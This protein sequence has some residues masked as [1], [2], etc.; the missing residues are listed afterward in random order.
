MPMLLGNVFQQL[1]NMIDSFVV[2]QFVGKQAL[3][4]VGQSFPVMFVSL[5]LIM[6]ITLAG[7]ILIAQF[8]G[9]REKGMM[10]DIVDATLWITKYVA[11]AMTVL[12][13]AAAPALL[14]L[15]QTPDDVMPS[16]VVF[17]RIVF[18]G[19]FASFAYNAVSSILRGFGDSKT[20]LYA[21]IASTLVNIALDFLFVL[22]FHWG[23]AGTAVATVIA[24]IVSLVWALAALKRK[25]PE[26]RVSVFFPRRN[27]FTAKKIFAIGLPSGAQQALVG[28][29]LMTVTGVVN[30]FG[31]NPAAAFSAAGKLDSFAI[32]PAL[33][34]GL[35]IST[36][37]GQNLGAG[38]KDRVR[39]GLFWG[40]VMALAISFSVTAAMY[41][42]GKDFMYL[43]S[44]DPEVIRIGV[45]YLRIVS[46]G[47]AFQTLMF[48]FSGVIRGAG[49]TLFTMF[50][51]LMAMWIVR[52]PFALVLSR[53]RGTAGIW[54]AIVI[55]FAVGMVGTILYYCFGKWDRGVASASM[56]V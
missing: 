17:L 50:M 55:G 33:N 49:A 31:T 11:I 51:T 36:F 12:G 19:S 14:A 28:A 1:Y 23:V 34:I 6:G 7:N 45:E 53:Y 47:Y 16:A 5:S 13:V 15:M 32:M 56:S 38:R 37:T 4:A 46:L 20:P 24:Q 41:L 27:L 52:I 42:F 39:R 48:C 22:V 54:W 44:S 40:S 30:G 35:A 18:L 43:F 2:G 9:A 25:H 29:G 10:Q 8:Y 26:L 3:A 21:L